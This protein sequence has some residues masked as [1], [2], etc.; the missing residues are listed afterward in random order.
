MR[1][2]IIPLFLIFLVVVSTI[3]ILKPKETGQT[4][5]MKLRDEFSV[6]KISSVDHSK[7]K[8]LQKKFTSPQEVTETC[9]SCHTERHTEVMKSNHWNWE[10]AEYVE[11]RGIVYLGKKNALN[12]FCIGADDNEQACAKCHIGYGMNEKDFSFENERYVDC[13]VC[14]DNTETYVKAPEKGGAPVKTLN[15]NEIAMSVGNTKRS[16]CGVCHFYGGGGDNVKH[17]DLGSSMFA[18]SKEIDVHMAVEGVNMECTECHTTENHNIS[19]KM[20]SLSSMNLNRTTCEQCHTG[21]PH[22]NDVLNQHTYKVSCQTCHIPEYAKGG[23]ATKMTWDWST[24]GKLKDGKPYQED[25]EHGHHTYLSTKGSF[26]YATNVKP[27]YIWFNGKASH[28]LLG[29]KIA[30][31]SKPLIINELH[32]SYNDPGSKIIPVK[33]HKSNQPYD[34]VN[35]MLIKP[36]LFSEKEGEGAYWKD[37]DWVKASETG[38]KNVNLP[39]SGKVDFIE[40]E[41]YW[42]LNHMVATKE[43]TVKCTECHTN[44]GS[45]LENVEGF[46]MPAR[47]NNQLVDNGGMAMIIMSILGVMMHAGVRIFSSKKRAKRG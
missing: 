34:P 8:V 22:Q 45:R 15:L 44:E 40:T 30:D 36:K 9:I 16:N 6:E 35:K 20:Y 23:N 42:P 4:H 38:M 25:D 31:T 33:I 29:D 3:G 46:Y 21:N 28:Y 2:I 11:G 13:L 41:M 10:R 17:G 1:K 24:A 43:N 32:G 12:N 37:F 5:L 26:T 47:D 19:G 7:F 27:E 18:P 14:H 39:F